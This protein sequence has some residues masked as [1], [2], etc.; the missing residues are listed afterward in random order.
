MCPLSSFPLPPLELSVKQMP[1]IGS[2]DSIG[3]STKTK[4]PNMMSSTTNYIQ[5][6][7]VKEGLG[8]VLFRAVAARETRNFLDSKTQRWIS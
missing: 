8:C 2:M 6:F 3:C 4:W 5:G 7:R 1:T